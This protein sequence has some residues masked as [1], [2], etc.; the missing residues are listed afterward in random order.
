M[1][2]TELKVSRIGNS[3]G[4]R[5]PAALLK[6]YRIGPAVLM[7]EASDGIFLRPIGSAVEKLS[8]EDTACEMARSGEDWSEWETTAA[9]GLEGLDWEPSGSRKIA[10]KRAAYGSLRR[11]KTLSVFRY[12]VRWVSLDPTRGAE[13]GKKRPAVIVSLDALNERLETVTVCPLTSQ[14]H[15][16]WRSRRSIRLNRKDAEIAVDQIRVI[17]KSRVGTKLGALNEDEA[18]AL[19]RV[20]T[21]MYGE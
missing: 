8:W 18:S 21:E 5:L 11:A 19:R 16:H 3:R 20:I 12:E 7:E 4:V 17:S 1:K 15:P 13:M 14:L 10:E 6:R 9:D 2:S